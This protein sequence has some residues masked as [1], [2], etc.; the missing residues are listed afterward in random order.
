LQ[1][2]GIKGQRYL[3]DQDRQSAHARRRARDFEEHLRKIIEEGR[4][5]MSD[6]EDAEE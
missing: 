3:T 4:R 5:G 1:N 6:P 2:S